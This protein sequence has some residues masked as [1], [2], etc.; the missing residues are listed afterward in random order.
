[1]WDC[2]E[3]R[4]ASADVTQP[5]QAR[6]SV[7]EIWAGGRSEGGRSV[8]KPTSHSFYNLLGCV[9]DQG[10]RSLT[11]PEDGLVAGKVS[12]GFMHATPGDM[13]SFKSSYDKIALMFAVAVAVPSVTRRWILL[14]RSWSWS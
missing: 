8:L 13:K 10:R 9:E 2:I 14:L 5:E 4:T 6:Q 3:T 12:T 11:C 7:R 1:M